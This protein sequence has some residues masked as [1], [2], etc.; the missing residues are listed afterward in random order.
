M[1]S[2]GKHGARQDDALEKEVHGLLQ[3]GHANRAEEWRDPE[4]PGED[5][6]DVSRAPDSTG[7]GGTPAGMT[8]ADVDLRTDIAR[9]LGLSAFP[10]DRDSLAAVAR[11]NGA[12]DLVTDRL[13][14][15][16]A[17]QEFENVQAVMR[18][19]GVPVEA[20]RS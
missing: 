19:L 5:Q 16:P 9:V 15:L 11:D 2:A 18:A 20:E 4:P 14:Q 13:S 10:G 1:E 7:R 8:Q 12:S 3:G 17:G 6:P